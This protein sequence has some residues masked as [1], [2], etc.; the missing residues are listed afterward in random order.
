MFTSPHRP[1]PPVQRESHPLASET[2]VISISQLRR[3]AAKGLG[4][5]IGGG[6]PYE[7]QAIFLAHRRCGGQFDT[8][9]PTSRY[10]TCKRLL[11]TEVAKR[12]SSFITDATDAK[13][14]P[15]GFGSNLP[16]SPQFPIITGTTA[17]RT[18]RSMDDYGDAVRVVLPLS[19]HVRAEGVARWRWHAES[20]QHRAGP[21]VRS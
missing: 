17:P 12:V 7:M 15:N 20:A 13:Q 18:A 8:T 4:E 10:G 3:I 2:M 21:L 19:P 5:L 14:R 1:D 9:A 6:H 11:E 16:T